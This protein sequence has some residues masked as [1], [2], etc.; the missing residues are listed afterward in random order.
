MRRLPPADQGGVASVQR[1][2]KLRHGRR[3]GQVWGNKGGTAVALRFNGHKM[4][5]VNTHLA[6]HTEKWAKRNSDI[7]AIV[8]EVHF[9][10]YSQVEFHTQ[11]LLRGVYMLQNPINLPAHL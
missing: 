7:E 9:G 3:S 10:N 5:F 6:A 1:A 2:A 11:Y 8:Q 4:A